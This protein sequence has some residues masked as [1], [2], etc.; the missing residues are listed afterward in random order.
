MRLSLCGC[1]AWYACQALCQVASGRTSSG[2]GLACA[3]CTCQLEP[4]TKAAFDHICA[5]TPLASM[6]HLRGKV[7]PAIEVTSQISLDR[8]PPSPNKETKSLTRNLPPSTIVVKSK[9]VAMPEA[10]KQPFNSRQAFQ[11]LA[12]KEASIR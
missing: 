9:L 4:Y 2:S 12:R 7:T 6:H 10:Q 1:R 8:H 5:T 3:A 11:S